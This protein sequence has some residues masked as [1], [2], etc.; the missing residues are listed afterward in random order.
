MATEVQQTVLPPWIYLDNNCEFSY[1]YRPYFKISGDLFDWF[2]LGHDHYLMVFGDISGHGIHSAL[3]MVAVQSL[4]KQMLTV[5]SNQMYQPHLIL[6]K[7]NAYFSEKLKMHLYMTCLVCIWNFKTNTVLFQNAGHPDMLCFH[8]DDG[9]TESTNIHKKG[10]LPVG[11]MPDTEYR[12]EDNVLFQFSENSMFLIFSDGVIDLRNEDHKRTE[13]SAETLLQLASVIAKDG[14]CFNAPFRLCSTLEQIGFTQ[15]TDD[16]TVLALKKYSGSIDKPEFRQKIFPDTASIERAMRKI[17]AYIIATFN[18]KILADKVKILL[19]EFLTNI[20]AHCTEDIQ[21][22][23]D[24]IAVYITGD[25]R[26]LS[27]TVWDRGEDLEYSSHFQS[28]ESLKKLSQEFTDE[29]E[30]NGHGIPLIL[31]ISP[32]IKRRHYCGINE[33]VFMIQYTKGSNNGCDN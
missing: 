17:T 15:V 7:L 18:S 8:T 5:D 21:N 32:Q 22:D 29:Q 30:H 23:S 6:K 2:P 24:A 1:I 3:T 16:L 14:C 33:T 9:G 20:A 28:E 31:K 13:V 19:H 27:I 10:N 25:K 26:Q 11:M 4:L 12:E